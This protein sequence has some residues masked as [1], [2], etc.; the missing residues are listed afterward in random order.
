M[1]QPSS[2]D[3]ELLS[4]YLDGQLSKTDAARLESRIKSDPELRS[5]YD[6]LRQTR[7]L[8]RQLPSRRAP[9]NFRLTPQMVGKRA[10]PRSFPIFRLASVL[11]TVLLFLG[12]AVNLAASANPMAAATSMPYA[13][14]YMAPAATAPAE[15]LPTLVEEATATSEL[16]QGAAPKLSATATPEVM[17]LSQ[18]DTITPENRSMAATSNQTNTVVVPPAPPLPINPGWLYGLLGMAVFSGVTAFFVRLRAAPRKLTTKDFLL[19]T[20]ALAVVIMLALSIYSM[21]LR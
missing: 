18:Q 19:M 20:L 6:G 13:D 14:T 9:R 4:A 16:P 2:Y 1:T 12:Y 8:L 17:T 11:A 10:L 5:V 7:A 21:S 3:L 15:M